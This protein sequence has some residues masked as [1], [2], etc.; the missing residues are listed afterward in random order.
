MPKP[1]PWSTL[2]PSTRTTAS[3]LRVVPLAPA[4][5]FVRMVALLP[6]ALRPGVLLATIIALTWF[7]FIRRGVPSLWR[8]TCRGLAV[9][10]DLA[11]GAALFPEYVLT[12]ARRSRG[13]AP[14]AFTRAVG[15]V[16]QNMLAAATAFYEHNLPKA[17]GSVGAS[18]DAKPQPP[19]AT[20]K[21]TVKRASEKKFPGVWCLLAVAACAGAWIT[22]DQMSS[23][24]DAKR[25]LAEGFEYWRDVE[26]WAN[27][28]ASRRAAPGDPLAPALVSASYHKRYVHMALRCPESDACAGTVTVRTVTGAIVA[29]RAVELAAESREVITVSLPNRPRSTL[30][31]LHIDIAA[32]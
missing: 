2:K 32:P 27:V 26:A 8:R 25:T 23:T 4:Q 5:W 3:S 31:H 1:T 10:L 14:G 19:T 7:V 6:V 16:A 28:D 15:A 11:I 30:E 21:P 13:Q 29:S 12:T 20:S 24:E 22:M 18:K 17:P 9:S